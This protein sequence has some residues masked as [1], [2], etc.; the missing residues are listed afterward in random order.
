MYLT[1]LVRSRKEKKK[2]IWNS[3]KIMVR[4]KSVFAWYVKK[5]KQRDNYVAKNSEN[6]IVLKNVVTF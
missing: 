1:I 6:I 4:K 2:Q 3:D 5:T